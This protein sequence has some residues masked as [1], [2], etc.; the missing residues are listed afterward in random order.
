MVD[1]IDRGDDP[2]EVAAVDAVLMGE[3]LVLWVDAGEDAELSGDTRLTGLV[4]M[5]GTNGRMRVF[6]RCSTVFVP[7][8]RLSLPFRLSKHSD[9]R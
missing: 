3:A 2:T 7:F 5:Y 8:V 1:E 9:N 6:A 4:S